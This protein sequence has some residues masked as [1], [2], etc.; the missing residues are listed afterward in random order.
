MHRLLPPTWGNLK[1]NVRLLAADWHAG[2]PL[3]RYF[4]ASQLAS[5]ALLGLC[6]IGSVVAAIAGWQATNLQLLGAAAI[7]LVHSVGTWN[8]LKRRFQ[9]RYEIW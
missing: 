2:G 9:V 4:I 6:S 5:G 3:L 8:I 7:C 1:R